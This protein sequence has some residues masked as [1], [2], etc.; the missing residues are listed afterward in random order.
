MRAPGA[1]RPA[2]GS[3][4]AMTAAALQAECPTLSPAASTA[5]AA[6]SRPVS[7]PHAPGVERRG[8]ELAAVDARAG[9]ADEQVA[10]LERRAS[11]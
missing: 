8:C 2:S 4:T 11:R 7:T 5:A 1:C 3:S 9:Q 6:C 10:G